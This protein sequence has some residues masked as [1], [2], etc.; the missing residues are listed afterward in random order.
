MTSDET[1]RTHAHS[2]LFIGLHS[3][4]GPAHWHDEFGEHLAEDLAE[5]ELAKQ[6]DWR[7]HNVELVTIGVDIGSATSH[8]MFSKIFIQLVGE[9]PLVRSVV[10]ARRHR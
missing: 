10:V 7:K 8:V 3:H 6:L 9:A 2:G 4:G 5:E 1:Q